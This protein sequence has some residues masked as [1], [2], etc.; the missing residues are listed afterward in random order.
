M[1][2][3]ESNARLDADKIRAEPRREISLDVE[4]QL[5]VNSRRRYLPIR[6]LVD[7]R[8]VYDLTCHAIICVE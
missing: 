4:G 3:V 1:R 6:G 5:A 8:R 7:A 2:A